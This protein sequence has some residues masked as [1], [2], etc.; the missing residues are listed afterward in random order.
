MSNAGAMLV[1]PFNKPFEEEIESWN[2][3]LVLVSNVLDEW[4]RFQF[5]WM[6]LQPIF[7]SPDIVR[8]LPAESKLFKHIDIFYK[9]LSSMKQTPNVMIICK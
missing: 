1:N 9:Q 8:Q 5:Q 4:K 6:Y 7:D 3:S 2:Q